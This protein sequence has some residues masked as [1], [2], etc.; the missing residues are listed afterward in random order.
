MLRVIEKHGYKEP[1]A[2][3]RQAIPA[4]LNGRDVIGV[5]KTG[6]GKTLAFVLPMIR[7]ILDQPP[8]AD[9]EGPIGLILAPARELA[10]QIFNEVKKFCK[11]AGLQATAV[12]GGSSVSDQIASL[13]RG[14]D[15]VVR[16][17]WGA[18]ACVGIGCCFEAADYSHTPAWLYS[19]PHRSAPQVA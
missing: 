9:G 2:I 12:Y 16:W 14:A 10:V 13:K 18:C 1:F 5:A 4:I 3:Q 6:S 15:V 19:S 8:L 7:H 17:S 11:P